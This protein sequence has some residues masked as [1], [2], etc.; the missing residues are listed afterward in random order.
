MFDEDKIPATFISYAADI[1]GDTNAGLSGGEIVKA[2]AAYAVEYDVTLPHPAYP[3][4]APNKRTALYANLMGFSGPLQY[5]I[6]MDL[7]AHRTFSQ[8]E[9]KDRHE[10]KLRLA[11]RYPQFAGAAPA[12]DINETLIEETRHWLDGHKAALA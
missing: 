9:N 5:R 2:R 3:F 11:M 7:C 4:D 6:I 1:L 12:A 8:V 10:L